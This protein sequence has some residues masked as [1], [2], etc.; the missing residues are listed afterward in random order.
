MARLEGE[1]LRPSE[2]LETRK[3]IERRPRNPAA[4]FAAERT[5][6]HVTLQRKAANGA[7]R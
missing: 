6:G 5:R 7:I 4:G 2:Q 3:V 1:K